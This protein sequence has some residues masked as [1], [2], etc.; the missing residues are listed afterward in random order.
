MMV[1]YK[2]DIVLSKNP[3]YD[4]TQ[5]LHPAIVWDD[6]TSGD[7][8]FTGIMLT[9]ADAAKGYN[10]VTMAPEH[11][12]TGFKIVY[13]QSHFV[14]QRFVKF[15]SWGAFEKV[16]ELTAEGIKF[17]EEKISTAPVIPFEIY[18]QKTKL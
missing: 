12:S 17:I 10:N 4:K 13:K 9:K 1:F 8:D 11:F 18:I 15:A 14:N 2:G 6:K 3:T 16:G 5:L 7:S